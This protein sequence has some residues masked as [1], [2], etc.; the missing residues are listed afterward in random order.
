ML[1]IYT[2]VIFSFLLQYISI[3]AKNHD[4]FITLVSIIN[5]PVVVVGI[6]VIGLDN[7]INRFFSHKV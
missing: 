7:A 3:N 2:I 5:I 1:Q 4:K 6:V